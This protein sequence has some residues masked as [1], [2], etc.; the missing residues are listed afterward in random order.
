MGHSLRRAS[1][2]LSL[3]ITLTALGAVPLGA[4]SAN[5]EITR[6]PSAHRSGRKL[7]TERIRRAAR[8]GETGETRLAASAGGRCDS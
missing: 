2:A 5:L 4:Q 3:L 1:I 7:G 6:D 8:G